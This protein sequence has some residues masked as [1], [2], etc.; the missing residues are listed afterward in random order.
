MFKITDEIV[1]SHIDNIIDLTHKLAESKLSVLVGPNGTGKSLIRKQIGVQLYRKYKYNVLR[2]VSME[3][4]TNTYS[5]LGALSSIFR[6]NDVEPTSICTLDLIEKMHNNVSSSSKKVYLVIDEPE[7]G[8]SIE[9]QL[10]IAK[11]IVELKEYIDNPY[12]GILVI[13]H[14]PTIL[15]RLVNSG[16]EFNYIG[17]NTTHCSYD[18][19]KNREIV[20]T[21]FEWL[22][23]WSNQLFL[24]VR[25]RSTSARK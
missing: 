10:G 24:R 15:D 17:Y 21:D 19:Y 7:I 4:R 6:D 23:D 11:K 1:D 13:T 3:L 9:S 14:S 18:D 16:F 22:K 25:D 2:H 5:E 20:E 8:M 12:L